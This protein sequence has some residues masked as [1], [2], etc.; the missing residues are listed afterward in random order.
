MAS[1]H[2]RA[3]KEAPMNIRKSTFFQAI[4]A[5]ISLGAVP[6]DGSFWFDP[7]RT[8]TAKPA[9]RP[10]IP[11]ADWSPVSLSLSRPLGRGRPRSD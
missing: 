10:Q 6:V 9:R 11:D 2:S 8:G 7:K 3:G 4:F 5:R 1:G